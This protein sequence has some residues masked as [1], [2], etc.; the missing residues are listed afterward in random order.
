M[1]T[2]TGGSHATNT[3]STTDTIRGGYDTPRT[4]LPRVRST[5][6]RK[7]FRTTE[8][9]AFVVV[10]ALTLLSAYTQEAFDIDQAW[11]LVAV[12]TSFYMLSRGIA[13]AGSREPRYDDGDR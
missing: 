6:T 8:F 5:E 2:Q 13:K 4:H 9:V 1:S 7:S 12:I 11:T 10:S 3:G